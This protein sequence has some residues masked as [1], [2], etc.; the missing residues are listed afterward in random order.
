MSDN[1]IEK[2]ADTVTLKVKSQDQDEIHFKIKRN[3]PLKKLME[4]YCERIN[5]TMN[6]ANFIFEGEKICSY[7]TPNDLNMR[8]NDEITV[9]IE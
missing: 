3:M 4:K 9:I 5:I 1:K 2:E 7:H 6:S 8:N